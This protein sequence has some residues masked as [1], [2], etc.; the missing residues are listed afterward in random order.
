MRPP[1]GDES[2]GAER[3]AL[4]NRGAE[5]GI[6]V[7]G[8][9]A[10]W[11]HTVGKGVVSPYLDRYVVQNETMRDD[12]Q[13]YHGIDPTK[14]VV[15]GWPQ[16]DIFHQRYPRSAY[17]ELLRS[18]GMEVGKPVVLYAGNTPTN[19]PYEGNVVT[20][21]VDWWARKA[22]DRFSLLFRPHPRDKKVGERFARALAEK[23]V[24][25]QGAS[26]MDIGDLALLL[27]NVDCVVANAGTVL[28]DALVNDRPAVCVLYDEGAPVGEAWA[29]LNVVGDHY[30]EL[31]LSDAFYRA[32]SF[33]GLVRGIE[34]SLE[35]PAELGRE[36][37]RVSASTVGVV[38]GRAA[39]RVAGAL[40]GRVGS[41]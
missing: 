27:Q 16:T 38:D 30:Q 21:L 11:D 29:R 24:G 18:L 19:S 31:A 33:E 7:V 9:V 22:H 15:T 17:Y 40:V 41:A 12:L 36:R 10:S 23:G 14:V 3:D 5:A 37:K 4:P 25:V 8:Y 2:P 35:R 26:Y 39:E 13:H 1:R 20:R 34:R 28:L 32:E 6:E